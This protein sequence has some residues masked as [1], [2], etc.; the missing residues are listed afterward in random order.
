MLQRIKV[1]VR[2]SKAVAALEYAILIGVIVV[3]IGLALNTLTTAIN[4]EIDSAKDDIEDITNR[5]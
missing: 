3:G 4:T 5:P 2:D 1:F